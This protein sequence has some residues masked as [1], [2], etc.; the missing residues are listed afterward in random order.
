[1]KNQK[2]TRQVSVLFS[3][4][5]YHYMSEIAKEEYGLPVSAYVRGLVRNELDCWREEKE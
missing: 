5:D 3:Q 1:M 4:Q 2:L